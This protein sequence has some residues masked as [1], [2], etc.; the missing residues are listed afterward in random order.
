MMNGFIASYPLSPTVSIKTKRTIGDKLRSIP[1]TDIRSAL[2]ASHGED[3][4]SLCT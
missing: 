1:E 2:A 4:D 3:H